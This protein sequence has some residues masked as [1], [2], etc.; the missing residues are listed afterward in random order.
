MINGTMGCNASQWRKTI[1]KSIGEERVPPGYTN[2]F[3]A[4]LTRDS[5]RKTKLALLPQRYGRQATVWT[6][7]GN[8]KATSATWSVGQELEAIVRSL[9]D[10]GVQFEHYELPGARREGD[11]HFFGDFRAAWFKDPDGN[12]L[13]VNS[14]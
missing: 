9:K 13:H 10:A 14:A 7:C 11:I 6:R 8:Q 2:Q 3:P 4:V 1:I 5:T 12:I